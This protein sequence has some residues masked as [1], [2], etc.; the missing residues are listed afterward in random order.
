MADDVAARQPDDAK[1]QNAIAVA[2]STIGAHERALTAFARVATLMPEHGEV[3]ANLAL[4]QQNVGDLT[5]AAT[6]RR[7]IG[8]SPGSMR[9]LYGLVQLEKQTADA[10]WIAPLERVFAQPH[11]TGLSALYAGHALAKTYEDFGDLPRAMEWLQRAKQQRGAQ[12]PYRHAD[13]VAL[14]EAAMAARGAGAGCDS[15]APIFIVGMPRTGTSL[16]DRILSSHAEVESAGEISNFAQVLKAMA[17][18]P[19][20]LSLDP[21]TLAAARGLD[22]ARLGGAYIDS[23]RPLIGA[24]ARF[25]NKTPINYLLAG[26]ILSALPNAR[27]ICMLRDP[28]DAGLSLYRQMFATEHPY[29]DYHFDQADT[30]RALALFL[31]V[32]RHW[33]ETLPGERYMELRYENVVGDLEGEARRLLDFCGLDW[34]PGVLAFHENKSAIAT[35]SSAQVRQPLYRGAIGRWRAYG[36]LLEPLRAALAGEGVAETLDG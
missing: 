14:A 19:G 31:R 28:M 8:L 23:T 34:D 11:P 1:A 21:A 16:A 13:A 4:A 36:A 35:P 29:Y 10:N 2:C 3:A 6:F 9:A 25:I 32:A 33:R 18:T 30:G 7:A 27:V 20:P 5:A 22:M 15:P 26:V 17:S 12:R 24:R